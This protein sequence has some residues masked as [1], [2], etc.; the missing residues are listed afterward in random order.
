MV[1]NMLVQLLSGELI[2]LNLFPVASQWIWKSTPF[3]LYVYGPTQYALGHWTHSE[4]LHGL[5]MA[6]AWMMGLS[7]LIR[8]SWGWGIRKYSSLGG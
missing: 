1:K 4:Y 5:G 8:L 6:I 7:V 2:P 3:Y